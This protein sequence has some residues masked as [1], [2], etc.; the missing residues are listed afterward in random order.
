MLPREERRKSPL[1]GSLL[2]CPLAGK[3]P[4]LPSKAPGK[5]PTHYQLFLRPGTTGAAGLVVG[6]NKLRSNHR[7]RALSMW[8]Q[9]LFCELRCWR[10]S[11]VVQRWGSCLLVPGTWVLYLVQEDSTSC[12]ATKPEYRNRRV[13]ALQWEIPH[14]ATRI[15]LAATQT[16]GSWISEQTNKSIF[17][18]A[19]WYLLFFFTINPGAP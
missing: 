3:A 17:K 12:G 4:A 7:S 11:L 13:Q 9:S 19:H 15:P 18:I 5:T 8:R 2:Y 6:G 16:Q 1:R 10:T 14:D